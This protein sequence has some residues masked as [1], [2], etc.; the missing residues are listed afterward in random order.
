MLTAYRGGRDECRNV[1]LYVGSSSLYR[2]P[3]TV[4]PILGSRLM[5]SVRRPCCHTVSTLRG[6]GAK[7][8]KSDTRSCFSACPIAAGGSCHLL[9]LL[10]AS[11][12][13]R[14]LSQ[15]SQSPSILLEANRHARQSSWNPQNTKSRHKTANGT[16]P[17]E[18]PRKLAGASPPPSL[19]FSRR[20]CPSSR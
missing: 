8:S 2:T 9:L 15:A 19:L 5:L 13:C 12:S 20:P 16:F 7:N 18:A 3:T 17:G 4:D 1:M 11:A 14:V 10:G 6:N